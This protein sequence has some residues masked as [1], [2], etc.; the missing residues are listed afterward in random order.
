MERIIENQRFLQKVFHPDE[1]EYAG[2]RFYPAQHF[3]SSFAA[4]EAFA[5]AS[6]LSLSS[7]IYQGVWV[8]RTS[9]GPVLCMSDRVRSLISL[10]DPVIS[11]L[12]LSHEAGLSIAFVVLEVNK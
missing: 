3:A 11:H 8:N 5:K 9:N 6:G 7:V 4:R 12:S 2:S 1:I 10:D